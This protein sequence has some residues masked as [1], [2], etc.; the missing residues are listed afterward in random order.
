MIR[1]RGIRKSYRLTGAQSGELPVLRGVDFDVADGEFAAVVGRSGSGKSTLLALLGGLDSDY[2]GEL[3]VAGKELRTLSDAEL[4]AYRNATIGFVFQ[5]FHLLDHLSCEDNV[6]LPALFRVNGKESKD[7]RLARAREL[8]EMVGIADKIGARPSTLSGGQKQRLAIARALY[9]K[10][11]LLICDEPTGNLDSTS[12][13]AIIALFRRLRDESGV[14]LTIVT[15][16]PTIA[17]AADRVIEI[18]DGVVELAGNGG[19]E[20]RA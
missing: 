19:E 16:D 3:K 1:A 9:H 20:V 2:S 15:H 11:Q 17:A 13:A 14:T 6:A 5:A 12:A 7:V 18:K 10:P 8:M 4:S